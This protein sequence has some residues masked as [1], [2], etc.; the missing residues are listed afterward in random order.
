MDV[1]GTDTLI[2]EDSKDVRGGGSVCSTAAVNVDV[3]ATKFQ[4]FTWAFL[5]PNPSVADWSSS[6]GHLGVENRTNSFS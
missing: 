2:R 6:R 5:A 3:T 4:K 1:A